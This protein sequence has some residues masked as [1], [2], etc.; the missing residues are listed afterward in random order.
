MNAIETFF[1]S[2]CIS[3]GLTNKFLRYVRCVLCVYNF[4]ISILFLRLLFFFLVCLLV[5][6]WWHDSFL[7][8]KDKFSS[9]QQQ[10]RF[11]SIS[12]IAY[13]IYSSSWLYRIF[14]LLLFFISLFNERNRNLLST[15]QIQWSII[16]KPSKTN[17]RNEKLKMRIK[18]LKTEENWGK[19]YETH[20]IYL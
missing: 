19:N 3:E 18:T 5:S 17:E 7:F 11:I 13:D 14:Y 6:Y 9:R 4:L 20:N 2:K 15:H 8:N 1:G 12:T 10:K 16:P